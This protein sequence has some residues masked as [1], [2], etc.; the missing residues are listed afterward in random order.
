MCCGN[1]T[2]KKVGNVE[3]PK[4]KQS[5]DSVRQK[6]AL[7]V[8]NQDSFIELFLLPY[9]RM[10]KEKGY[11]IHVA[12]DTDKPIDFCDKK[13]KLPIKR[14]P[15]EF[16]DNSQAIK[17]LR[18]V[19]TKEQYEFV[20]CHTPVGGVVARL[21]AKGARKAGTRV[22]YTAHGFHF[23]KGA[24]QHFW[25]MFYPVEKFLAKY[26]DTLITI[27]DEDYKLASRKFARRC[28]DIQYVPGVGVDARKFSK[29]MSDAD[30]T[31]YRKILG[32]NETDKVLICNG[33]I[34]AN[35]NQEFLIGVMKK[36][37]AKDPSYHLLL[38]GLDE[39]NG[40][41]QKMVKSFGL[42]DK[43]HFLGFHKD[44]PELLQIAD[45]VLSASKREGL[46]VALTEAA[47][48]GILIVATNCRGNRDVC[49]QAG[50]MIVKQGDV[51]GFV[52][53]IVNAC[54]GSIVVDDEKRKEF[55]EKHD[56]KN[57]V[58]MMEKIYFGEKNEK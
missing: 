29:R 57:V 22:I 47:M 19:I 34:D 40:K 6:K 48:M 43:V 8:A 13:I 50:Q 28:H 2:D 45:V 32:L 1:I 49:K 18:E 5:I 26:T 7:F 30:R 3:N 41:C 25:M 9:A 23:Y 42:E 24:P 17:E 31:K 46:P 14:S 12:T 39:N 27:N 54:K 38:V 44:I 20:H 55:A 56:V 51:K 4:L 15:F 37:V 35:K 52:R 16:R 21:A 33:R 10:L 11:E 36:L 53:G 58:V